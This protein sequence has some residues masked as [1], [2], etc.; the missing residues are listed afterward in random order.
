MESIVA[1]LN[2]SFGDLPAS[3]PM[4]LRGGNSLDDYQAAPAFD[5]ELDRITPEYLETYF[6]GISYLDTQSWRFYL[7]HLLGYALKNTANPHS[8]ATDSFLSSLRPPDRDPPRFGSLTVAEEQV[9]VA[10]L[11]K[12]AFS[13][14]SVWQESAQVALEEYWA[15]GATYR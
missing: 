10:V 1:N 14:Q 13:D 4:S 8:N 9:V 12:L 7:P 3:P 5:P 6:W 15:P 2:K 11:D